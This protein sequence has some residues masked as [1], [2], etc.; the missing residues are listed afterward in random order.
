MISEDLGLC[1]KLKQR[2]KFVCF[3]DKKIK[4]SSDI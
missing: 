1:A 4:I 3:L 2:I